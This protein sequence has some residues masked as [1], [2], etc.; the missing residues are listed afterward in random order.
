[1]IILLYGLDTYR[2]RQKLKEIIERYQSIYKSGLNLKFFDLKEKNFDDFKNEIHSVSMFKEKKLFVLKNASFNKEFKKRFLEKIKD[3]SLSKEIIL[4]FEEEILNKD[5]FFEEIKKVAKFQEFKPLDDF[6]LRFWIKE[7]VKKYNLRIEEK[8]ITK[9][10]EFVGNN[11]WQMENE[12]RKLAA[13]KMSGEITQSDVEKLVT[14]SFEANIFKTIDA[15][16]KKDKKKALKSLKNHL[17]KGEKIPYIFSMI[18]FE[19]RNLLM[20]KDLFE[21]RVPISEIKRQTELHSFVIEKCLPLVREFQL[22]ELKRIYQKIF[23]LDSAIKSGKIEPET[24]LTLFISQ[25]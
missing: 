2:S 18:K 4:F 14:P 17:E 16:A 23:E 15:I 22:A 10:I 5:N 8:A 13:F 21:K 20:I 9:L 12:I 25:I 1:M 7:E 6:R 3:F 11:L 24:A 19:F